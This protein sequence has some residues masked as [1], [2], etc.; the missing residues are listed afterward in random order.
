M[1]LTEQRLNHN[2]QTSNKEI[3][4]ALSNVLANAGSWYVSKTNN[5]STNVNEQD[6]NKV[7]KF[8][9]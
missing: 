8:M 4:T 5:K 7:L 1:T 2:K 6:A 3:I 9:D